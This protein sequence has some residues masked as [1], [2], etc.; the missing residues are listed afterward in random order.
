MTDYNIIKEKPHYAILDGLRG[1]AAVFVLLFHLCE[2]C[3]INLG[4]CYLGVDFF[5]ALSGFVVGYAYDDRWGKMGVGTFFKRRALRLHPMVVMGTA[6]GLVLYWFG[7][8]SAFPLI[9]ETPWWKVLAM[10]VWCCLML[11]MPNSWDIRGGGWQS[12]NSFNGNIWSLYWEYAANILYALVFRL[13]PTAALAVVVGIAA[14]GTL[15]LTLNLDVFGIYAASRECGAYSV[16][17]GWCLTGA[18][19]YI[20]FVRVL[21]PFTVGLLL[22]RFTGIR[23]SL[24]GGFGWSSLLVIA[25][26]LVPMFSGIANGLYEAVSI[27]LLIPVIVL[28]GAGS[29]IASP[30][31]GAICRFLGDIS[32]PL[33]ITHLPFIFMQMAWLRNNPD[34]PVSSVI[35][36]SVCLFFVSIATAY[37]S[38]RLY[39][40]PVRA[41][42]ASRLFKR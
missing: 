36:L 17:G 22:A 6:V 9:G 32:Y 15:D 12:F 14:L 28:I 1:V 42:L 33:Y 30:K 38:L 31:A 5:Y 35:L 34:A 24:R 23:I 8:S 41:W 29:R 11:P 39:D 16:N 27:L 3:G 7:Q 2:G 21:Y 26:M 13:L 10:F 37:A 4:H 18:E 25:M 40:L 19:L 20:G